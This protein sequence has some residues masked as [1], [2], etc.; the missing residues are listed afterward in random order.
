MK[1]KSLVVSIFLII[2]LAAWLFCTSIFE[3]KSKELLSMLEEAQIKSESVELNKYIFKVKLKGVNIGSRAYVDEAVFYIIPP[4][5]KAKF[6]LYGNEVEPALKNEKEIFYAPNGKGCGWLDLT[7]GSVSG[8]IKYED[9]IL[10]LKTKDITKKEGYSFF[11]LDFNSIFGGESP[12]FELNL[13]RE[14]KSGDIKHS[15]FPKNYADTLE[16]ASYPIKTSLN[17]KLECGRDILKSLDDIFRAGTVNL[18]GAASLLQTLYKTPFSFE[19][20]GTE[21]NAVAE[22]EMKLNFVGNDEILKLVFAGDTRFIANQDVRLALAKAAGSDVYKHIQGSPSFI[23]GNDLDLKKMSEEDFQKL[24]FDLS[25]ADKLS[26]NFELEGIKKENILKDKIDIALDDFKI[27]LTGGGDLALFSQEIKIENA[28]D[29]VAAI[30]SFFD[31]NIIPSVIKTSSDVQFNETLQHVSSNLKNSLPDLLKELSINKAFA[32][33][34][35]FVGLAEYRGGELFLNG[36]TL[37]Q[38]RE[39]LAKIF[40]TK[41]LS[42][43]PTQAKK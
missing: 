5:G 33:G 20:Y 31:K 24:G 3:D 29:K 10:A 25:S 37:D 13:K 12:Y 15:D 42:P 17:L 35:D 11:L 9:F 18:S 26:F 6:T 32:K 8:N 2:I 27:F 36:M 30:S 43:D 4:I 1:T 39:L 34:S 41:S 14:I 19:L 16:E 22:N 7:K 21:K 38:V 23:I 40:T 28:N